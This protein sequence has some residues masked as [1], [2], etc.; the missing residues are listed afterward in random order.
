MLAV[1]LVSLGAIVSVLSGSSR[2]SLAIS[3]LVLLALFAPTQLPTGAQQGWAGDLLLRVNPLT[4][5]EHYVGRIVVDDHPW[6]QDLSWLVSPIV[7]A[8]L[9]AVVAATVGARCMRLNA[10]AAA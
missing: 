6:S 2:T 1:F 5:G 10:G 4:A 7:G 8:A 9:C 3:L